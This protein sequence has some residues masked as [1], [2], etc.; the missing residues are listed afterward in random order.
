MFFSLLLVI[1]RRRTSQATARAM[2]IAV[3]PLTAPPIMAGALLRDGLTDDPLLVALALGIAVAVVVIVAV[4][5]G[6]K[7]V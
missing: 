5:F 7:L 6:S 2:T 4:A 1:L 3:P